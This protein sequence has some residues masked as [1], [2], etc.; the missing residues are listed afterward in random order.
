MLRA[1]QGETERELNMSVTRRIDVCDGCI[2]AVLFRLHALAGSARACRRPHSRH[3]VGLRERGKINDS[4][5]SGR[6]DLTSPP[7]DE[8]SNTR[9]QAKTRGSVNGA[10]TEGYGTG[11]EVTRSDGVLG[12]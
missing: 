10:S 6:Q 4:A 8:R 7:L 5:W 9:D 2:Q 1:P 3:A 11:R 12:N